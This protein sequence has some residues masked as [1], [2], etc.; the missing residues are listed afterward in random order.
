MR[1]VC[2]HVCTNESVHLLSFVPVFL[3]GERKIWELLA[4]VA[5]I[6]GSV[7]GHGAVCDQKPS[8]FFVSK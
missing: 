3:G 1:Q 5:S 6:G 8:K 7:C 2:V 4:V